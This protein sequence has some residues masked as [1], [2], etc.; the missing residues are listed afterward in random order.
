MK[1]LR[2]KWKL[3]NFVYGI[4]FIE[5]FEERHLDNIYEKSAEMRNIFIILCAFLN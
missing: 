4:S 2:S 5:N 1:K 3:L